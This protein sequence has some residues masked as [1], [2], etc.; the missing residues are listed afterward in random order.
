[1]RPHYVIC[2]ATAAAMT[3]LTLPAAA[4]SLTSADIKDGGTIPAVHIY[5]RCG[6]QNVSP[7]LSWSGQ[8]AAAKSLVLTMIDIDVKPT[9]WSQWIVTGLPAMSTGLPRG[10]KTLP[11]G[12]KAAVSNFGDAAYDGPCPPA[13]SG[14]HHYQFTIWAMPTAD[15]TIAADA[16]ANEILVDLSQK[17]IAHAAFTAAVAR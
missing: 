11:D 17:A 8:P 16:P 15:V 7:A 1:M 9:L 13:G 6:G 14:T 10:V 2:A 12:A 3:A 4:M 5:T